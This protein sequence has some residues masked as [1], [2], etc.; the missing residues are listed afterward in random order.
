MSIRNLEPQAV[1]NHFADLNAVPRASKKEEQVIQFMK[2][3][4][5]K[6]NLETH[7]DQVGNVIIKKPA[8]IGMEDRKTIILQ[9]HLDMVHQKNSD[10]DFDFATQGIDMIIEN[11][12]VKANGTTLGADNGM[13]V[14]MMMTLLSSTGIPHPAIECLFTID[15]ETGMTGAQHLD[16]THLSG[17]ILLNLDTEEDD[18]IDV[19]CAGG[20][21]TSANGT[22]N[23]KAPKNNSTAFELTLKGLQG[24]HSGMEIHLG[25]GNANKLMNR[26]L[27]TL[28]KEYGIEISLIKGGGL[29]NAIPRESFAIFTVSHDQVSSL[30]ETYNTITSSIQAEYKVMAPNLSFELKDASLPEKV[31]VK[32]DQKSLLQSI[33]ACFNGVFKMSADIEGLVETSSNL[34][35]ITLENGS[36][37]MQSLQRSSIESSKW[38]VAKT[39]ATP[40]HLLG[41]KV[42]HAGSYPGW[43]PEMDA[44]ILQ[45]AKKTYIDMFKEEP[46]VVACH[47]GLEC[48]LLK[49]HLPN[50]QM[51]SFGP[52]ILGAHSPDERIN[53]ASVQKFWNY[54]LEV[55]KEIPKK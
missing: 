53:I 18:E 27:Y 8:S 55:I 35:K 50:T 13:G 20:V 54:L 52:T 32:E 14:A 29:R 49:K 21:D 16:A 30:K 12:W 10:V 44:P 31:M 48:G 38:D 43:Q 7:V 2:E 15:E 24:G 4:G 17:E 1:W 33:Y 41:Y 47:A 19:G 5:E 45:V 42:T 28:S 22:Y 3:F 25:L 39:V 37:E 51:I 36:F 34:A 40:F 6:L 11:E 9:S 26:I 23:Q 46:K